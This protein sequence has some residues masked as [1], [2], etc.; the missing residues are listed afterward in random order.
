MR[1]AGAL[2]ALCNLL[3]FWPVLFHGRVF[4]SHDV[5]LSLHPW[6]A[7]S[8]IDLPRNRLLADPATSSETLLRNFRKLPEGFFWNRSTGGGAPGPVNLVQGNLS[9]FFWLPALALPEAGIE[10]GILFLKLNVSFLFAYLFFRRRRFSENAASAGAAAWA[11]SSVQTYWWLWMQT[12]V[13]AFFPLLLWSVDVAIES[14][15]FAPAAAAAAWVFLGLFAGGYPF[16]IF[17]GAILVAFAFLSRIGEFPSR[18]MLAA[19]ARLSC[20]AAI[21]LAILLPAGLV[22]FRFLKETGEIERRAGLGAQNPMPLRQLRLY[23]APGYAGNAP[24]ESYTGVGF[25]PMDNPFETASAVG[26][27]ALGFAALAVASRRRRRLV[28]LA[29]A[30]A[31]LVGVPLYAGGS[32]LRAVGS[33]PGFSAGHFHRAKVLIVLAIAIAC[34]AGVEVLEELFRGRKILPRI[35]SAVPYAIA[36]PLVFLAARN[37]PAVTPAKAVFA[38]T[39]GIE[40]LLES[41][42]ASPARFLGTG[43]TFMPNLSEAFGIED[44]RS[45]LMH[46][47]AYVDLLRAADPDV[48]G[49]FGTFLIFGPRSFDPSSPVLDLLNVTRIAAPPGVGQPDSREAALQDPVY[50]FS[51]ETRRVSPAGERSRAPLPLAYSGPDMT[52]FSR[53]GAFSRFF[54]VGQVRA[55]GVAE[56][57]SASRG[58]LAS[59]AFVPADTVAPLAKT[60]SDSRLANSRLADLHLA[61]SRL[62]IA[63]YRSERFAVSVETKAP[64]FLASSQKLFDPYWRGYLDGRPAPVARTD[65]LFF[66]MLVPAGKHLVE[67]KFRIPGREIALSAIGIAALLSLTLAAGTLSRS[68]RRTTGTPL[69]SSEPSPEA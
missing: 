64:V 34:A 66:G 27:F 65:G 11:L 41:E 51:A 59:T 44:V 17:F 63:D 50:L 5:A 21:A 69:R 56:A 36:V 30:L 37:Y 19:A 33:L 4:S 31:L 2:L 52:L 18:A 3:F 48:Y 38:P 68:R 39:P 62:S 28:L 9:P 60:L 47:Q 35:L 61:D 8:G 58:D 7:S 54:L 25:G 10:T 23:I 43:W 53:P 49:S 29:A 46:E 20:A 6:K 16:W 67:G 1:R 15:S 12:S 14:P 26:P 24:D 45:H 32:I 40:K 55:G 13:S 57:A 22:S 42:S